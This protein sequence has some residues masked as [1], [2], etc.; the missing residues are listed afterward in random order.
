MLSTEPFGIELVASSGERLAGL[1]RFSHQEIPA[2]SSAIGS[3]RV[4]NVPDGPASAVL[5]FAGADVDL[6]PLP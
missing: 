2:G 1:V 5:V 3:V 6:Q 4:E